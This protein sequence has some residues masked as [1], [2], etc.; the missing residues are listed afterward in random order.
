MKFVFIIKNMTHRY[1]FFISTVCHVSSFKLNAQ[2]RW[3]INNYLLWIWTQCAKN[4]LNFWINHIIGP[5]SYLRCFG[6]RCKVLCLN[7]WDF[8]TVILEM[9]EINWQCLF[10]NTCSYSVHHCPGSLLF[11]DPLLPWPLHH[12][13]K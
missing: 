4:Y 5:L 13:V 2:E 6:L 8:G 11:L 9:L 3:I 10:V 12:N 7:I 1:S